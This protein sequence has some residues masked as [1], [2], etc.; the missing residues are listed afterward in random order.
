MGD[1]EEAAL[2]VADSGVFPLKP[3]M[4]VSIRL[5]PPRAGAWGVM[6]RILDHGAATFPEYGAP[7]RGRPTQQF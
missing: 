5:F 7:G 2:A 4:V 3:G 6:E 1:E